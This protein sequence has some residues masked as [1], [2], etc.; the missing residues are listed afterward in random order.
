MFTLYTTPLSSL[1]YSQKLYLI[2]RQ[3]IPKYTYVY[4]QQTLIFLLNNLVTVSVIHLA[5]WQTTKPRLNANKT[6]FIIIDTSRHPSKLTRFLHT[7][8]LTHS[9]TPSNTLCNFC[10]TLHF[11]FRKIFFWN[12]APASIK[13]FTFAVF[14]AI[15]LF[16]SP[17]SLLQYSLIVGLCATTLF[18]SA[19]H[20]RIF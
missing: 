12:V 13:F 15:F 4:L 16:Q 6:Y 17:K 8:I 18:F 14:G 10:L 7:N 3:M 11:K 9:I 19:F 1:T 2:Y 5:G 20:L